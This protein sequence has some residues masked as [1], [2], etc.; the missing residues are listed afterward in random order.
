[1]PEIMVSRD[2]I[3]L[4]TRGFSDQIFENSKML[5][6]QAVDSISIF[7]RTFGFVWNCLEI[8]DLDG[9]NLGTVSFARD[10][11]ADSIPTKYCILQGFSL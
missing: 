2:R 10:P 1:V 4:P 6:L 11:S 8:F 7:H 3:E 5:Q 9:H